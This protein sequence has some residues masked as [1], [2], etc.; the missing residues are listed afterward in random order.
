VRRLLAHRDARSYLAGQILSV[1]DYRILLA[2]MATVMLAAA[3]FLA[4]VPGSAGNTA[5]RGMTT[6]SNRVQR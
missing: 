4:R 1:L 3:G 2:V 5:T 6:A